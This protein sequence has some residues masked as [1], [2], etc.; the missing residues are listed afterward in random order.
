LSRA[1]TIGS[2]AGFDPDVIVGGSADDTIVAV[3]GGIDRIKC[4]PG[5]N[6]VIKDRA[7]AAVRLRANGLGHLHFLACS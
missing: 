3:G 7:D 6:R 1:A 2:T 5:R 4:G